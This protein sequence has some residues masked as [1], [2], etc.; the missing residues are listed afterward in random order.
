VRSNFRHPTPREDR[1]QPIA[2]G[3]PTANEVA[4]ARFIHM[5]I[6]S[7]RSSLPGRLF[8]GVQQFGT[9]Q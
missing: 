8:S 1:A 5:R 7:G 2:S 6:G 3:K 9:G 4:T